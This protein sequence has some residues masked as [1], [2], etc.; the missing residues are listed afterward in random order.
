VT[1]D[2]ITKKV[3]GDKEYKC[4]WQICPRELPKDMNPMALE[5]YITED[6]VLH[7]IHMYTDDRSENWFREIRGYT[8]FR[9]VD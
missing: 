5:L 2:D 4:M 6:S 1:N 7:L 9:Q 3:F 8:H